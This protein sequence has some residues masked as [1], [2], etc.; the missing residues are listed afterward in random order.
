MSIRKTRSAGQNKGTFVDVAGQS[1]FLDSNIKQIILSKH[2]E[3]SKFIGRVADV[4]RE[5]DLIKKSRISQRTKLYYRFFDDIF[6]GKY[7]VVV[8]K[9]VERNFVSTIYVTDKIKEGE[10]LW[11][12]NS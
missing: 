3:V 7:M 10:V 1:I 8:V 5:P 9:Q 2:P 4:L 11:Q 12:K 6:N